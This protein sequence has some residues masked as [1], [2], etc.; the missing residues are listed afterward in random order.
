MGSQTMET[1]GINLQIITWLRNVEIMWMG[2]NG[3]WLHTKFENLGNRKRIEK[4]LR[5]AVFDAN[6]WFCCCGCWYSCWPEMSKINERYDEMPDLVQIHDLR[7]C[8]SS[9]SRKTSLKPR[10]VGHECA[11]FTIVWEWRRRWIRWSRLHRLLRAWDYNK[12][13]ECL[14][15]NVN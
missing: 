7:R 8:T 5:P 2:N 11:Q 4:L 14:Q 3:M 10:L 1:V 12:K 6:C 15:T 9:H 13:Y